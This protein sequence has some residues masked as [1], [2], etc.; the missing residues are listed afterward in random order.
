MVLAGCGGGSGGG[1]ESVENADSGFLRATPSARLCPI[2]PG[3]AGVRREWLTSDGL[4]RTLPSHDPRVVT[5]TVDVPA[6]VAGG[7]D[8]FFAARIVR[9][10]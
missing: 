1:E 3:E 10:N 9:T 5:A 8:G 4:L 7:M 6:P 2:R